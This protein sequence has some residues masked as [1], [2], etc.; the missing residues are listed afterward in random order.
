MDK[1]SKKNSVQNKNVTP[2]NKGLKFVNQIH[3]SGCFIACA[4]ML[5][6][7]TYEEVFKILH[8]K[9]SIYDISVAGLP[10]RRNML[11]SLTV[12]DAIAILPKLGIKAAPANFKDIMN[13]RKAGKDA[14][15][16]VRWDGSRQGHGFVY[17][18]NRDWFWDPNNSFQSYDRF[19]ANSSVWG[20]TIEKVLL[21]N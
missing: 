3:T 17:D 21:V 11:A 15:M 12:P 10:T 14:L 1:S 6:G 2:K 8:P 18:S 4:A 5:S 7:K 16:I 19:G 13:I 20:G 9:R